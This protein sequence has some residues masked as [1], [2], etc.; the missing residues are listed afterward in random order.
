MSKYTFLATAILAAATWCSPVFGATLYDITFTGDSYYGVGLPGASF[1]YDPNPG[2]SQ[3]LLN[4]DGFAFDLTTAA[5]NFSADQTDA[6][7]ENQTGA[8][9]AFAL[10]TNC[11]SPFW[12]VISYSPFSQFNISVSEADDFSGINRM[13]DQITSGFTAGY[14]QWIGS[15]STAAVPEPTPMV[16]TF[17]ALLALAF[18]GCKRNVLGLSRACRTKS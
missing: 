14:G 15:F 13:Y 2:F 5:N 16:L 10:L 18:V 3:F 6:C 12:Y 1:L 17:T 4:W 11:P 9:A 7:L 8:Q